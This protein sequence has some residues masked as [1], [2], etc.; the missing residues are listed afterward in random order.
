MEIRL[1]EKQGETERLNEA[2]DRLRRRNAELEAS[3]GGPRVSNFEVCAGAGVWGG[4][5]AGEGSLCR[6]GRVW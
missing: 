5:G 3:L 2:L 1:Q 4:G 6:E